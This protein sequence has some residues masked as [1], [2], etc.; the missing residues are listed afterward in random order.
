MVEW[1]PLSTA[2]IVQISAT[3][4]LA[5]VAFLA[6]YVIFRLQRT[7][8]APRLQASYRHEQPM[9]RRS[10]RTVQ[11]RGAGPVV[12]D[13]HFELKNT[14][15]TPAR[16]VVAEIVEFWHE[17]EPGKLVKLDEFMPVYLRYHQTE[18]VDVHP[19]RPYYWN[20]GDI[21]P[22]RLQRTWNKGSVY[23]AP[24]KQGN[25]L[26]FRLDLYSAP[27]NQV[28]ALLKGTYGLKIALYSENAKPEIIHLRLT[29]SGK[30]RASLQDMLSEIIMQE[31][32][33]FR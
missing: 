28:N 8:L 33:P 30:W 23:D 29:W 24:G 12:F 1:T 11:G 15:R 10:S 3:C 26:R 19:E 2:E 7:Y 31:A 4:L 6:P 27:H 14:G 16:N 22:H 5:I 21:Y 25:G 32:K 13:F 17:A 9:A 20:I 18:F